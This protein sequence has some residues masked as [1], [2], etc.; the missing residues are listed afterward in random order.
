MIFLS[1]KTLPAGIVGKN[2]ILGE[3]VN[4][5][6]S[7]YCEVGRSLHKVQLVEY[8]IISAYILLSRV[9]PASEKERTE[10][11]WSRMTL[12][13]LLKSVCKSPL[14]D[15]AKR[16]I[17]TVVAARNHLAHSFFVSKTEVHSEDGITKLLREVEAMS[18]VFDRAYDFFE[19]ILANLALQAGIDLGAIKKESEAIVLQLGSDLL[20]DS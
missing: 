10:E 1:R 6:E 13:Q 2:K 12:G 17:E 16:F 20:E 7:L 3:K 15:E 8:N 5:I 18:D 9:G 4:S 14:P 11:Y 19:H